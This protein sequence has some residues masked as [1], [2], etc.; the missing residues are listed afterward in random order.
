MIEKCET[1]CVSDLYR[2]IEELRTAVNALLESSEQNLNSQ[3]HT[4]PAISP[5]Q[6]KLPWCVECDQDIG[7]NVYCSNC[8]ADSKTAGKCVGR[9]KKF[10][11]L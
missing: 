5:H 7:S 8:L 10:M 2:T 4:Q 9:C 6:G 11:S 3:Q 1:H